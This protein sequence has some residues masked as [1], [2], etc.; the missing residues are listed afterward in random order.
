MNETSAN[1]QRLSFQDLKARVGVD[2]IA[3]ALGYR[4]DRRAGVGRFFE[5]VLRNGSKKVD[6]L[7]VRNT[8]NK[9]AQTYFRR[10]GSHGDVVTLVR[11]NLSSFN[12]QGK[13]EWCQITDVL[14][15]FANIPA[16]EYRKDLE[17]ISSS[18]GS[19][20]F[21][22]NRYDIKALDS[23][24]IP[25]LF[26]QRGL[27]IETVMMFAPYISLISDRM[28]RNFK[29]YNIGF[30]YTAKCQEDVVGYEIRGYN[31]FKSKAAGTNSST[32]A[33]IADFSNGNCA[34]VS[35]VFF[36]ES[37]FDAMA[38]YQV[39]KHKLDKDI[40]LVSIGGTFSDGQVLSVMDRFPNARLTD[41]FDNDLA[42]RINALRLLS[43]AE[44]IP[45]KLKGSGNHIEITAKG[46]TFSID[47]S[48]PVHV[49]VGEHLSL[50]YKLGQFVPPPSFKDW[51]D[52]LLGKSIKPDL[53]PTKED[54]DENLAKIRKSSMKL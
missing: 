23:N 30:P 42:G 14:S 54:R 24:N 20:P 11:E 32:G 28:N 46:K 45:M 7:I 10:D 52:C 39:N 34:T 41:C 5:L 18:K 51:N 13:N 31:G 1:K 50:R 15:K 43:I 48:R 22:P 19:N 53:S 44:N 47:A 49:A 40:A 38:F 17:T 9:A 26:A 33:W 27:N 8:T 25:R 2:D 21:D 16:A 36:F 4:L 29:G 6:T 3:Y 37:A 35:N 12:V